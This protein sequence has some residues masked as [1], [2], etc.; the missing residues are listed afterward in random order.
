MNGFDDISLTMQM[1]DRIRRYEEKMAK[2]TPWIS[3][4]G[5]LKRR[6][7]SGPVKVDAVP[8]PKTNRGEEL[9]EPLEW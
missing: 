4:A 5:Y 8:V 2:E 9:E 7:G 3:D 6:V 1:E